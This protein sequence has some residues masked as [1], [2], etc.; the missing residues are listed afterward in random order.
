[1]TFKNWLILEKDDLDKK[2]RN[3]SGFRLL[4]LASAVIGL[5]VSFIILWQR[6]HSLQMQLIDQS[7]IDWV[8]FNKTPAWNQF[9]CQMTNLADNSVIIFFGFILFAILMTKRR[10]RAAMV[11][12]ASLAGSAL[13]VYLTKHYF[14]RPRPV[15]CWRND[16]FSFPSGHATMASYFYGLL[17]YLVF[18]FLPVS[19]KKFMLVF[20]LSLLIIILVSFSRLFLEYHY[21]S[22]IIAGLFLG[23]AWLLVAILLIDILYHRV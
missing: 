11:S 9:F 23:G 6:T 2:I 22:D 3:Y 17:T 5:A 8:R 1:M 7:V 14:G 18:R 4:L 10:K 19:L 13:F 20:I 15:D 16:C 21:F 12:L